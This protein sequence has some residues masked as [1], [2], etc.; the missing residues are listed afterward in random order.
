MIVICLTGGDG[1]D[2][3]KTAVKA[4]SAAILARILVMNANYLGQL[5]SHPSLSIILHQAGF[6]PEENVLLYLVDVWLDKVSFTNTS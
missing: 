1:S 4:S 3:L 2:P 6:L 5:T